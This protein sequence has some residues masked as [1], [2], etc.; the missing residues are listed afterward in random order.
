MTEGH[1]QTRAKQIEQI[2][3]E[4]PHLDHLMISTILD[5]PAE[6]LYT[7]I[8]DNNS[9]TNNPYRNPENL[10]LKTVEIN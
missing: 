2:Q 3:A 8:S 6:L 9:E 1:I 4:Y 10:I 7:I 5:T